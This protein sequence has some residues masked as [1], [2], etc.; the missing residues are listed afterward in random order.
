MFVTSHAL[1]VA[2]EAL[3]AI[4]SFPNKTPEIG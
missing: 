1:E 4:P 2:E 3:F